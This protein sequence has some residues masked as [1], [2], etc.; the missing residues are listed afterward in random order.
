[1][2]Q[3][4]AKEPTVTK[5][6]PKDTND[7]GVLLSDVDPADGSQEVRDNKGKQGILDGTTADQLPEQPVDEAYASGLLA[8]RKWEQEQGKLAEVPDPDNKK[9]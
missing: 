4:K 7:K 6:E 2:A 5:V 8:K 3:D 9:D 1:M